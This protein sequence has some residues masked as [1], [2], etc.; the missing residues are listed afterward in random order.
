MPLHT[1]QQ[2]RSLSLSLSLFLNIGY[3]II[4]PISIHCCFFGLILYSQ[5]VLRKTFSFKSDYSSIVSSVYRQ[6][7]NFLKLFRAPQMNENYRFGS[8]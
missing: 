7:C 6:H 8:T 5:P 1:C 4:A 2:F 3:I